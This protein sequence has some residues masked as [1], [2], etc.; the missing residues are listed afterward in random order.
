MPEIERGELA[1]YWKRRGAPAECHDQ[2][3]SLREHQPCIALTTGTGLPLCTQGG[4]V[5]TFSVDVLQAMGD[6]FAVKGIAHE[7]AHSVL[8]ARGEKNHWAEPRTTETC[9][10]AERAVDH[11]LRSWGVEQTDLIQWSRKWD[12]QHHP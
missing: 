7:M 4:P 9:N 12:E 2:W 11:L 6:D 1:E 3:Q 10:A 5:L 8:Y